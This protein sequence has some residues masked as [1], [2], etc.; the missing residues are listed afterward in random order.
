MNEEFVPFELAKKL[1]EKGFNVCVC[2][3]YR[4]SGVLSICNTPINANALSNEFS[5]PTISQLLKWLREVK[6]RHVT[7]GYNNVSKWRYIVIPLE[8]DFEKEVNV[9]EKNFETYEQA[10]LAGITYCLDTLI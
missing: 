1:K 4:E 7:T 5:A 8:A 9:W 6:K 10:V 2:G 3:N